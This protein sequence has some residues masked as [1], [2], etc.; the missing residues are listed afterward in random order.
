MAETVLS[1]E[2]TFEKAKQGNRAV[3]IE[4]ARIV[5]ALVIGGAV[6]FAAWRLVSYLVSRL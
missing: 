6:I 3:W 1:A 4:E 5:T 2:V